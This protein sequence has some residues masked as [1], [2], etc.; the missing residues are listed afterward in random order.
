MASY[1]M[2]GEALTWYQDAIN[3]GQFKGW[4]SFVKALQAS[5]TAYDD[6]IKALT[7]SNKLPLLLLIRY[8]LK[9]CPIN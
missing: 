5:S 8:N 9:V 7:R 4:D 3:T 1:H 6:P 2:E